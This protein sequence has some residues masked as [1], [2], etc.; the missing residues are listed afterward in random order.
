MRK[1]SHKNGKMS[2]ML[3]GGAGCMD[4]HYPIFST[5]SASMNM[6]MRNYKVEGGKWFYLTPHSLSQQSWHQLTFGSWAHVCWT[7]ALPYFEWL[8]TGK[9]NTFLY[10]V[11]KYLN[12]IQRYLIIIYVQI[13]KNLNKDSHTQVKRICVWWMLDKSMMPAYWP[14]VYLSLL[15]VICFQLCMQPCCAFSIWESKII[16][17]HSLAPIVMDLEIYRWI[18]RGI[19][20]QKQMKKIKITWSFFT[21]E[22]IC[23]LESCFFNQAWLFHCKFYILSHQQQ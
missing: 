23:S 14:W 11:Q 9:S 7:K 16:T 6:F 8:Y 10:K 12:I 4:V 17:F 21:L 3:D 15:A 2:A 20:I 18:P 22:K 1:N 13:I 5:T 19:K